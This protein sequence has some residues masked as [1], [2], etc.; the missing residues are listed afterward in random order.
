[1]TNATSSTF[2][3]LRTGENRT[4]SRALQIGSY[5]LEQAHCVSFLFFWFNLHFL[6]L[7]QKL[8]FAN[9]RMF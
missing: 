2:F 1:M 4:R 6:F 8:H 3:Q 7:K 9:Q 5:G